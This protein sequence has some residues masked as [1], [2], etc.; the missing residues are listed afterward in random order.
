MKI[1]V[2]CRDMNDAF[3]L[4]GTT[5]VVT[6]CRRG[7]GRAAALALAAAGADIVGRECVARADGGDV[8]REVEAL[9]RELPRLPLRLR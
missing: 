2:D 7:I 1:L 6:G 5:A 8:G 3:D 9:G 4:A